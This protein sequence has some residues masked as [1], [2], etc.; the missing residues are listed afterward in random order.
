[1][2]ETVKFLIEEIGKSILIRLII[3]FQKNN[4]N[5]FRFMNLNFALYL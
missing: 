2:D 5:F 4:L 1:M 3:I